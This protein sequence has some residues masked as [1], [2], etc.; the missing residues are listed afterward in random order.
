MT[1]NHDTDDLAALRAEVREH[2]S[3]WNDQTALYFADAATR[4]ECG[5]RDGL[6][7]VYTFTAVLGGDE[8]QLSWEPHDGWDGPSELAD[9]LVAEI[10]RLKQEVARRGAALVDARKCV[11]VRRVG[12]ERR[13]RPC[14]AAENDVSLRII[15]EALTRHGVT[16]DD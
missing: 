6:D 3:E 5:V 8:Y 15:N 11:R 10:R 16:L 14:C 13:P 4:I 12:F 9:L 7:P 1:S 2:A